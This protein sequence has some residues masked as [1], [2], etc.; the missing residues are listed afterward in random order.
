M[1][2][3]RKCLNLSLSAIFVFVEIWLFFLIHFTGPNHETGIVLRYACI[4]C[5]AVFALLTLVIELATVKENGESVKD[6]LLSGSRGNFLR[7]A[8]LFTLVADYFLVA[9]KESNH[10]AGVAVF[11][12]TQ[13][14]ICLHILAN[15]KNKK[16]FIANLITR[17]A[18]SFVLVIVAMIVLGKGA[19][20][21]ALISM[22]YY[23]NLCTNAIFAH[24]LGKGGI[25]L[26]VGLIFFALCDV[27]VGLSALNMLYGGF[28]E[29]SF[30]YNLL[31]SGVDL[32]WIFYIP[33]QTLIPLTL[34]F[35]KK[36]KN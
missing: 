33:S 15:E 34:L 29:G 32:V 36:N 3:I 30:F 2:N 18:L 21:L 20:T 19:D 8:M 14:F 26:T 28:P 23:A 10:L 16:W 13:L 17:A 4:I 11:I 1:L 5:A 24:R 25:I 6:V 27:N 9:A 35:P 22:V 31:Y 7:I 12:G